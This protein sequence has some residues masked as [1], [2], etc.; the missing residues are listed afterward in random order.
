MTEPDDLVAGGAPDARQVH[1][2][3][4]FRD[5][6]EGSVSAGYGTPPLDETLPTLVG[7]AARADGGG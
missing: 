7:G 4:E 1:G 5:M 6:P 2:S 3:I